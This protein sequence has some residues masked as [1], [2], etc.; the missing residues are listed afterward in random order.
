M[1]DDLISD[2]NESNVFSKLYISNAY[3][4]LELDEESR[5]ITTFTT[6]LGL[7][8]CKSLIFGV[9]VAAEIF[10]KTIADLIHDI[11]GAQ[12]LSDDIIIHGDVPWYNTVIT[13]QA[14][15]REKSQ[16]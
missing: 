8:R 7:F 15:K 5:Y 16:I 4:Q 6:Y 12:N 9:N 3:H 1:L 11:Q 14:S 2:L 13:G 10:Q